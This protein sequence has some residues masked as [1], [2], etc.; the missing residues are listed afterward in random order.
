MEQF[1]GMNRTMSTDPQTIFNAINDVVNDYG[2]KWEIL[3]TT[4]LKYLPNIELGNDII[5][6]TL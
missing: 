4:I 6:E 2:I 5:F 3:N 1:V